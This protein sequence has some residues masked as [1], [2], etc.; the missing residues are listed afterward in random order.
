MRILLATDGSSSADQ[1]RDLVA[2]LPWREG[3]LVRIASVAPTGIEHDEGLQKQRDALDA[4]EL[5]I[6]CGGGDLQ[7]ETVLIRGRAA[8]EIV[9]Q[10]GEFDADVVV[11]GHRG[12]G[13]W[14]ELLLG[15]VAAEVVDQA[16]CPVLVAR[17]ERLGPVILAEDGSTTAR[18]AECLVARWP[19]FSGLPV[20]VVTVGEDEPAARARARLSRGLGTNRYDDPLDVARRRRDDE[21]VLAAERLRDAGFEATAEHREGDPAHQIIACAADHEAG[22]IVIG[23]R[24]QSSL[25]RLRLGSVARKVLIH[26]PCSVLVVREGATLEGRRLERRREERELVSAF[27]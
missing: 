10:A 24:G 19:L 26:A 18:T 7:I 13:A 17:D 1:A 9:D 20:T 15:S 23:S 6:R 12:L 5:E 4:A 8:S 11:V 16:P 2:A 21:A 27:G 22:L 3:G 25:G 14:D